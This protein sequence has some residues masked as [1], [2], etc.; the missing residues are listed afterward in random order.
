MENKLEK[1]M[2]C[3]KNGDIEGLKKGLGISEISARLLINRDI[4]D[5]KEAKEFLD[6]DVGMLHSP[7]LMKGVEEA[8]KVISD[9]IKDG[10]RIRVVGDYDVDGI[11]ATYILTDAIGLCGGMVD[12]YIP[13]RI[14]DGY[15]INSDIIVQAADDGI[16]LVITCDNGIAA[17]DAAAK[18]RELGT[19]LIITDHHEI[20]D[21]MPDCDMIIPNARM[22]HIP[23]GISAALS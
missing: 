12:W 19:T 16:D 21:R 8:V 2:L 18:A 5:L 22:I 13:H 23:A 10:A 15:G 17:F 6:P 7:R 9:K 3:N 1:W 11:M 20:Q 4:R 14:R